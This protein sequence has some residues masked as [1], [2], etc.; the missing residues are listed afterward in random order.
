M[1][2]STTV[3]TEITGG[4]ALITLN[5]P[6]AMNAFNAAQRNELLA[7]VELVNN[8]SS[9][10]VV[11]LTG[12][13][14]GFSAGADLAEKLPADQTV[15]QRI[16]QQYK[17][18]L[19]GIAESSKSWIAAVNGAAAGMGASLALACDMIV[20]AQSGYFYQAFSTVGLIPDGGL[21]LH[22]QRQLGAKK[23]FEVIALAKKIGC[24]ECLDYGLVNMVCDNNKLMQTTDKL[25][26]DL[27]SKAPLSLRYAKEALRHASQQTLSDT[28]SMEARLQLIANQSDDHKEGKRA[29]LEKRKPVWTGK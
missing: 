15:E 8:K 4:R 14:R 19:L 18:I 9:V 16:N 27:L 5:R 11:V 13:G 17:P 25:A 6:D 12:A 3:I 22:L 20:M 28:I 1:N 2:E 7:A 24:D 23:A 21:S 26:D 10:R 29:F